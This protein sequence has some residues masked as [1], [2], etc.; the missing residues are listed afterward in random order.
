MAKKFHSINLQKS[1]IKGHE[2]KI[3][4]LIKNS[5]ELKKNP[6]CRNKQDFK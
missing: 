5:I 2:T 4:S 6:D 1:E 3:K